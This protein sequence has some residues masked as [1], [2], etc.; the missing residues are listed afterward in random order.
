MACGA[1]YNASLQFV[2][3]I[4]HTIFISHFTVQPESYTLTYSLMKKHLRV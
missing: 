2:T 3:G 1:G 4:L